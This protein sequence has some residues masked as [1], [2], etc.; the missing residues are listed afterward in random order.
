MHG[1]ACAI[2]LL[3]TVCCCCLSIYSSIIYVFFH[4]P[5]R[6]LMHLFCFIISELCVAA[7][8]SSCGFYVCMLLTASRLVALIGSMQQYMSRFCVCKEYEMQQ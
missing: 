6:P 7:V 3:A 2:Y 4:T 8:R 5:D 1:A